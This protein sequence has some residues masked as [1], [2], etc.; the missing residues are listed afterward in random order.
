MQ[1]TDP[2]PKRDRRIYILKA[3]DD[4]YAAFAKYTYLTAEQSVIIL[5]RGLDTVQKRF[6]VLFEAG[7]LN[8]VRESLV[9]PY[10][11]FLDRDGA[12]RACDLG[13]LE[14]PRYITSKSR[15]IVNHDLEI[16]KFHLALEDAINPFAPDKQLTPTVTSWR[17]W[18]DDLRDTVETSEGKHAMIPDAFFALDDGSP[19]HRKAFFL[20][21]VKSYE[22]EYQG[23]RSNIEQKLSLYQQYRPRFQEKY[24]HD[25]FRV[26]WVLPTVKRVQMLIGKIENDFPSRKFWFTDEASYKRDI[27]G[28]IWWT[29][30]DFRDRT[31]SIFEQA[32]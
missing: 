31:Y 18:R 26:L 13:E 21:I 30:K 19:I 28:K 12:K 6:Q 16:T 32:G 17:Q 14:T 20:E 24:G 9:D 8:R 7:I 15:M 2:S 4:I 22:S 27:L 3:D 11:Y 10:V 23:G 29:P 25:D 1:A 5:G